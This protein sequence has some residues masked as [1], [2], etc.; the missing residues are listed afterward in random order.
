MRRGPSQ[1]RTPTFIRRAV[2]RFSEPRK[3]T[4]SAE[5]ISG[6]SGFSGVVGGI[7]DVNGVLD[8]RPLISFGFWTE[9]HG[10]SLQWMRLI[11]C[12]FLE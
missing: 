10:W 4:V 1:T 11:S 8:L 2:E 9:E 7:A 3:P 6:Y 5:G 12:G